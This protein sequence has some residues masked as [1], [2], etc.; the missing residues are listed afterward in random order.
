MQSNLLYWQNSGFE[1]RQ[2]NAAAFLTGYFKMRGTTDSAFK[3]LETM[4]VLNNS[5][6]GKEKIREAQ[7][8]ST[9]EKIRQN[10]IVE[11]K[12]KAEEER[13][14]QLQ[15]LVIGIFIVLFFLLTLL[16]NRVK[17]HYRIIKFLGIVSLLMF[18]EYL[19]LL[20]HP[21]IEIITNHTPVFQILVFVIIAS[22]LTPTHHRVEHWLLK[23]LSNAKLLTKKQLAV[24]EELTDEKPEN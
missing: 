4:Q 23:R 11:N 22:I 1:T 3:Y 10:E 17:V 24:I 19:L 14:E 16:L 2:L 13:H 21:W 8:I 15:M 6:Y 9:N 18:F 7:L 20:L 5:V 12:R